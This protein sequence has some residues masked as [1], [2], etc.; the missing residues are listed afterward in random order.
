MG[1]FLRAGSRSVSNLYG[2]PE[3]P[4]IEGV[5]LEANCKTI[6][7]GVVRL[8]VHLR[9]KRFRLAAETTSV[10]SEAF[11][12]WRATL[13]AGLGLF[14]ATAGLCFGSPVP[15]F[16][17]ARKAG[18][19]NSEGAQVLAIDNSGNVLVTGSFSSFS[20]AVG[21]FTLTNTS[22]PNS[23]VFLAKYDP[24]GNVIWARRAGGSGNDDGLAIAVDDSDNIYLSGDFDSTNFTIGSLSLSNSGGYDAFIVKLDSSGNPLWGKQGGGSLAEFGYT[25][26]VDRVGQNVY[27]AG[28]FASSNA[29]FD[30]HTLT[31]LSTV[32][33][34]GDIFIAKYDS[35]GNVLWTR[36]A[37]GNDYDIPFGAA[38]D[39]SGNLVVAGY[40]FSTNLSF[41]NLVLTNA[42]SGV[43]H[44]DA[45]I[46]KY[47]PSGNVLWAKRAGGNDEDRVE[48]LTADSSG[49]AYVVG[50]FSSSNA[51]FG[52]IILTNTTPGYARVFTAKYDGAGTV[53]WARQLDATNGGTTHRIA[54][55]SFGDIYLA[56]TFSGIA[57]FGTNRLTSAGPLNI[58]I[59]K[60]DPNGLSVWGKRAGGSSIDYGSGV[61]VD[62]SGNL[63]VAGNFSSVDASWDNISLPNSGRN[64]MFIARIGYVQ[65]LLNIAR[66][67]NSML[68]FWPDSFSTF[69]LLAA[70]NLNGTPWLPLS[71]PPVRISDQM[72][73]VDP[74]EAG[75]KFYRLRGP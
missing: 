53:L 71:A 42:S 19:T 20:F 47:D 67:G 62:N 1:N 36:R 15:E 69:V 3:F 50:Y 64:D 72:V 45:F 9:G 43:R 17:W 8:G 74:I 57:T 27:L 58:Y 41:D 48:D 14:L 49:N 59:A 13:V 23:D 60:C 40:Y 21:D 38:A 65:P 31:N 55:D 25:L 16:L 10:R 4:S 26:A 28:T 18:G 73:V 34:A 37:G 6:I 61:G 35:A 7:S 22:A 75:W 30:G 46:A 11:P 70:T 32:S 2:P 39:G 54:L 63:Y 33:N 51:T 24:A 5:G 52:S 66:S 29:S 56:G 12:S 44:G 68:L